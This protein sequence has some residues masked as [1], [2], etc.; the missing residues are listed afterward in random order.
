MP[1]GRRGPEPSPGSPGEG[2]S[3]P[4]CRAP[5]SGQNQE[6]EQSTAD[7]A[8]QKQRVELDQG[9]EGLFPSTWGHSN[10]CTNL[11]PSSP[12]TWGQLQEGTREGRLRFKRELL[13]TELDSCPEM[14][15]I[16]FLAIK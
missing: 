14:N 2:E 9:Q 11:V 12:G 6:G 16:E 10:V 8:T 3:W 15:K 13:I 4:A 1:A 7:L 5:S